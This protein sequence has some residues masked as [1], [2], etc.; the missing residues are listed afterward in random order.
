MKVVLFFVYVNDAWDC[1]GV[2][3]F[4]VSLGSLF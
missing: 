4:L 2:S 3:F 1:K